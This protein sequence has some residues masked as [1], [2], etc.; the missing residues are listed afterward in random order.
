MIILIPCPFCGEA[1]PNV[2]SWPETVDTQQLKH[3]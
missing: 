2:V 3:F 1:Y